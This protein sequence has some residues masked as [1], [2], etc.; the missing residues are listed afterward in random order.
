M[1]PDYYEVLQVS[2]NA[3][4]DVIHTAYKRLALNYHPD[5]NHEPDAHEKMRVLNEAYET[6]SKPER[7][8][9]YDNQRRST[10]AAR[11]QAQG[12]LWKANTGE[13]QGTRARAQSEPIPDTLDELER[14]DRRIVAAIVLALIAMCWGPPLLVAILAGLVEILR[15]LF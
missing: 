8:R 11:S 7:R 2:P 4:A 1:G 15:C 13:T 14:R 6:L 3:D 5:R 10:K 9:A 12:P